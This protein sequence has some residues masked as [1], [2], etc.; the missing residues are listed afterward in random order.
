VA[1]TGAPSCRSRMAVRLALQHLLGS[2]SRAAAKIDVGFA[3]GVGVGVGVGSLGVGDGM[4]KSRSAQSDSES[5]CIFAASSDGSPWA[6]DSSS[7]QRISSQDI[8]RELEGYQIRAAGYTDMI[9]W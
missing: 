2:M 3:G 1:L 8:V 5:A 4:S 7:V 9:N 6:S